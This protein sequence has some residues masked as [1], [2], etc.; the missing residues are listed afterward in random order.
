MAFGT[1]G[2]VS[3]PRGR[4][5]HIDGRTGTVTLVCGPGCLPSDRAAPPGRPLADRYPLEE[6]RRAVGY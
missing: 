2:Y 3:T 6:L 4:L 1:D 5:W